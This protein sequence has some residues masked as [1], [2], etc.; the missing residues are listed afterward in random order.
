[1]EEQAH[2]LDEFETDHPQKDRYFRAFMFASSCYICF[3]AL[4][5][6]VDI[7]RFTLKPMEW[8][9]ALVILGL[10]IA[11]LLFFSAGKKFGWILSLLYYIFFCVLVLSTVIDKYYSE[12][13]IFNATAWKGYLI[14]LL[15]L[16]SVAFLLTK[17]VRKYFRVSTLLLGATTTI[18]VTVSLAIYFFAME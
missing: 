9:L 1:M 6:I 2:L 18:S 11:G 8:D 3:L 15:S 14:G 10:P 13:Q 7:E 5:F 4:D 17:S 12:R 16:L